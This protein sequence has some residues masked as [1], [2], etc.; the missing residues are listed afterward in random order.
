M[1]DSSEEALEFLKMN[2]DNEN[3]LLMDN[4]AT[5]GISTMLS[6]RM[7]MTTMMK[8]LPTQNRRS[9]IQSFPGI[10]EMSP[11][12]TPA[13]PP[14]LQTGNCSGTMPKTLPS[15]K[16]Q[17]SHSQHQRGFHPLS[18]R[19]PSGDNPSTSTASSA[20]STMLDLLRRMWAALEQQRSALM[21]LNQLEPSRQLLTGPLPGS[22]HVD[23]L[24]SSSLKERKRHFFMANISQVF[25]P[26]KSP[27]PTLKS[28]CMINPSRISCRVNTIISSQISDHSNKS[29]TPS[30]QSTGSIISVTDPLQSKRGLNQEHPH[31]LASGSTLADVPTPV[32]LA[33]TATSAPS[34]D[35]PGISKILVRQERDLMHMLQPKYLQ[36]NLWCTDSSLSICAANWM[37][38][39]PPLP[40]PPTIELS[41]P[42]IID[43]IKSHPHLFKIITPINVD[44]FEDLFSAHPNQPLVQSICQGLRHG[45]WP[46]GAN[47]QWGIYP[48][49]YDT[50]LPKLSDTMQASFMNAQHDIKIQKGR[51]SAPF[52]R[53]L[54]LGMYCMPVHAVPKP[55]SSDL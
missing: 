29:I 49:T 52:G 15:S 31:P 18:L 13:T 40:P 14:F 54:L 24:C 48:E 38:Y 32:K 10:T 53:S 21:Q 20:H 7:E 41:N 26:S 3:L 34:V 35:L 2:G 17:S 9:T 46:S 12:G 37:I 43:T 4:L 1:L 51:F 42:V 11:P 5:N 6:W 8:G 39:A 55:N 27:L 16:M 33:H 45:F 44:H 25:L 36:Y 30:Y 50:S 23:S 19:M 28:S 47:T 22:Q